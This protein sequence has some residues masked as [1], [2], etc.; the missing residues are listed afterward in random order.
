MEQKGEKFINEL[1]ERDIIQNITNKEKVINALN[2]DHKLYVGFDPSASSI[3]LGNFVVVNILSLCVKYGIKFVIIVGGITGMIGDPSGKKSERTLLDTNKV[4]DNV[5]SIKKQLGTLLP[6]SL[7]INN[8]SFYEGKTI[9]DF[10]REVG[11]YINISYLLNKEIIKSRLDSGISFTEFSYSLIQA[12]D[13]YILHEK[14]DVDVEIGGSDQWG[15]ITIGIDYVNKKAN[16]PESTSPLSGLTLKL[17][18]K[19][20]GTKF[21]KSEKGAVYLDGRVTAPYTMYQFLI[22]Q[23]DDD[24]LRLLNFLSNYSVQEIKDIMQEAE[25]DKSKRYAQMMLAKNII[26]RVHGKGVFERIQSLSAL[27]FKNDV[28]DFSKEDV[29]FILADFPIVKSD[30]KVGDKI[31]DLL[32]N[33]NIFESKNEIRTLV[34]QNGLSISGIKINDLESSLT[35]DM[36]IQDACIF[37]KKGKQDISII[38]K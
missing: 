4:L 1:M 18:L 24:C 5:E 19:S 2:N 20:D 10:L 25:K 6:N 32:L 36:I 13:F 34:N 11:K 35:K 16:L 28:N 21:G 15:N 30:F 29:E 17:L 23:A 31:V 38:A 26:D 22:N 9:I 27:I 3:H 14:Y 37:V 7:I 12:N 33:A 8:A